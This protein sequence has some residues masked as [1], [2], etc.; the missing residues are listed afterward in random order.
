MRP[1]AS[2]LEPHRSWISHLAF[3]PLGASRRLVRSDST[4]QE[5]RF[6]QYWL[7]VR[8]SENHRAA[9][10][11]MASGPTRSKSRKWRRPQCPGNR[12]ALSRVSEFPLA[13]HPRELP[14]ATGVTAIIVQQALRVLT[15]S[16]EPLWDR[17]LQAATLKRFTLVQKLWTMRLAC[18]SLRKTKGKFTLVKAPARTG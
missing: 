2:H 18:G 9:T 16:L 15:Y 14:A 13:I 6:Y 17:T 11:A 1:E 5:R 3:P 10:S 8:N 12:H 4:H 7:Q